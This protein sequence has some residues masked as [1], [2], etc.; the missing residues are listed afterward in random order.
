MI[1]KMS[2]REFVAITGA[3]LVGSAV[4]LK[5]PAAERPSQLYAY[6]SSWTRAMSQTF[7]FSGLDN[8]NAGGGIHVF[9]V[10]MADGSLTRLSKVAPELNCGYICISPNGKFLYA[11]DERKDFGGNPGAGGGVHAFSIDPADGS[12][13]HVN[14]HASMGAFPAYICID[15]TGLRVVTANHGSYDSVIKTVMHRAQAELETVYDDGVVAMFSVAQ[16]GAL[17]A[18]CDVSVLEAGHG[19]GGFLQGS[20]HPHSVN[21]DPG[22]RYLLACDK[23]ADRIYVYS[24]DPASGT[25]GTRQMFSSAPGTAPR[26]SAFHPR[27]PYVFIINELEASLT[28]F[29]FD[30]KTGAIRPIETVATIP[31]GLQSRG[32]KNMPA[33]IR[34]HPNGKFVYG[35]TRGNNSIAIFELDEATGKLTTVDIVA[36]GGMTPRAFNFEPSG[37][38]LFAANQESNNI[39]TFAVDAATGKITQTDAKAE[40]ERPVCLKF[41][42]L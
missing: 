39:V 9:A 1:E 5:S 15:A 12:L 6:A 38:Y 22:N 21:F 42:K 17:E 19:P 32:L 24:F 14:S 11:T 30:S 18:T 20:C 35:S 31:S 41:T 26:H 10:D 33:D 40:I 13:T 4:S 37:K 34:I 3:G 27:L 23:G 28:S 25:L 8:G 7:G 36:S 29:W 2:R 16:N